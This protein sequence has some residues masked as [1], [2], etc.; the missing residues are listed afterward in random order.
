MSREFYVDDVSLG[1]GL[2][3]VVHFLLLCPDFA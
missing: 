1:A 3:G 2:V